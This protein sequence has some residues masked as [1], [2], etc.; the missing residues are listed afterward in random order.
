MRTG[1]H[2]SISQS[3]V[4]FLSALFCSIIDYEGCTWPI[5][6]NQESEE[7]DEFRLRRRTCFVVRTPS[8]WPRSPCR[9][10]FGVFLTEAGFFFFFFVFF[11]CERTRP[12][13]CTRQPCLI[14]LSPRDVAVFDYEPKRLIIPG[15]VKASNIYV[16]DLFAVHCLLRFFALSLIGRAVRRRF[17]LT[18]RLKKRASLGYSAWDMFRPKRSR[19]GRG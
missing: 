4:Y 12:T 11:S 15:G 19:L 16:V 2:F 17:P 13:G 1:F 7:A 5:S 9:C 3:V 10:G 8:C 14:Q 6:T 18:R